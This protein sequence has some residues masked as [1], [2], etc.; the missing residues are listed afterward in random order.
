[1]RTLLFAIVSSMILTTLI[2]RTGLHYNMHGYMDTEEFLIL[3]TSLLLPF[4]SFFTKMVELF[5]ADLRPRRQILNRRDRSRGWHITCVPPHSTSQ[6]LGKTAVLPILCTSRDCPVIS[7]ILLTKQVRVT[8]LELL[9]LAKFIYLW[10]KKLMK[11]IK[12]FYG[13][14]WYRRSNIF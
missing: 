5:W 11:V 9:S 4:W 12:M 10:I 6:N 3:T 8:S 7:S 1:M 13:S 2:L 14:I